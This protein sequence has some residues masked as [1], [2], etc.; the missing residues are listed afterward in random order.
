LWSSGP[1]TTAED[2]LGRA[3]FIIAGLIG[4]MLAG[5]DRAGSS[6]DEVA[7]SQFVSINAAVKRGN[8][9]LSNEALRAYHE[10]F[11]RK[12]VWHATA[13]ILRANF[14][15]CNQ[16]FGQLYEHKR[17]RGPALDKAL[18]EVERRKS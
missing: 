10:D 14:E 8:L 17:V 18:A 6:L 12:E 13:A 15:P 9:P 7:L 16:L 3:R 11:W 4:E 5:Y 1:D 2:D